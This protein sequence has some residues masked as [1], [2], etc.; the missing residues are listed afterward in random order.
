MHPADLDQ[1]P[2][3]VTADCGLHSLLRPVCPNTKAG[4]WNYQILLLVHIQVNSQN[5]LAQLRFSCPKIDI[6]LISRRKRC[7]YSLEAPHRG[8]SNEN[9]QPM[10]SLRNKKSIY[11]II[12]ILFCQSY[13]L[14]VPEPS[15]LKFLTCP[16]GNGISWAWYFHSSD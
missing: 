6:F 16:Q 13:E 9:P 5:P 8:T 14:L 12:W 11:R 3:Y 2:H 10:F 1:M 7:G 15:K 4:M